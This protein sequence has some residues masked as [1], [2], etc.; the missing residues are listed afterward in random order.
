[1]SDFNQYY[2]YSVDGVKEKE[3]FKFSQ[4]NETLINTL[5]P[6]PKSTDSSY[7]KEYNDYYI[8][9]T[10]PKEPEVTHQDEH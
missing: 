10:E 9:M 3:G 1:M 6:L 5:R 2:S 8:P 7:V 4:A